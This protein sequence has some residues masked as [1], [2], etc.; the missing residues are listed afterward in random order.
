VSAEPVPVN[1]DAEPEAEFKTY[2]LTPLFDKVLVQADKEREM[3]KG[4]IALAEAHREAPC[5]GTVLAVGEGRLL[6]N[7]M[8]CPPR[9][10]VA[11]RI[12]FGKYAGVE[13][14]EEYGERLKI[15]REDEVLTVLSE[16][17]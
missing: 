2:A 4:G 9:V 14:P 12:L 5:A 13:L 15:L 8:I 10:S 3:T 16:G 1:G 17:A 7:G 6:D 11:Q